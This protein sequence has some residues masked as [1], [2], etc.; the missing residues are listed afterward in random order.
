MLTVLFF[1]IVIPVCIIVIAMIGI[2]IQMSFEDER[3]S[4]DPFCPQKPWENEPNK[5][6]K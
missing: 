4:E 6:E 1:L 3:Y 2:A 5:T